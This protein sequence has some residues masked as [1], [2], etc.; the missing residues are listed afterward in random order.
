MI[1]L[2]KHDSSTGPRSW[3]AYG[4]DGVVYGSVESGDISTGREFLEVFEDPAEFEI[5]LKQVE[6]DLPATLKES[7][8]YPT[9]PFGLLAYWRWKREGGGVKLPN[10]VELSTDEATQN[11]LGNFASQSIL[12]TAPPSIQWKMAGAFQ[13][14]SEEQVLVF[15]SCVTAHIAL[16]YAVESAIFE[17]MGALDSVEDFD[18][19]AAFDKAYEVGA[20]RLNLIA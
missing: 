19:I 17:Q 4:E 12:G 14:L 1:I 6:E 2:K 15:A 10:G 7:R 20:K 3:I 13:T 16:C 11:K 8:Q 9:E 18:P 5:R